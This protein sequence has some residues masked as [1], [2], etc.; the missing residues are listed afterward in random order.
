M[1]KFA[2]YKNKIIKPNEIYK[3]NI[4]V[5]SEFKCFNC[6]E[7]LLLRQSR[8]KNEN[9]VEHF[10][11]P[12]PCRNGTHIECDNINL[13][14]FIKMGEWHEMMSK[15]L[16]Y[17]FSEYFRYGNNTKHF[18]DGYD[19]NND[20]GIEF[21]NSAISIEDI[22]SREKITN[23]DWIFNVENQFIKFINTGKYCVV[24][25]PHKSWR[26]AVKYCENNVF[27]YTGFK[28][29]LWLTD[30]ES[31]Y[32]EIEGKLRHVWIIF[33]SDICIYKDVLENTCLDNIISEEG[34]KMFQDN[35]SKQNNI[36]HC[37]ICYARCKQSMYLLDEI[38]RRY[39]D[40][41]NFKKND[42]VAVKSVAGSGKTTTLL[43][44]SKINKT[45]KILYLAFNKNLIT[46][47][48]TKI[49]KQ[50]ITNL[51]PKTFDSLMRNI[52]CHH[53]DNPHKIDDLRPN[54]LH[55]K[56]TWFQNK[57]WRIK[58]QCIQY[59]T[60]FCRQTEHTSIDEYCIDKFGKSMPLLKM[61]WEKILKSYIITFDSIRKLVQI[62]H[63]A[64][65]YIDKNYDMIFIDEA[66]DFDGLMLDILLNDTTI[67]KV[68]VGDPLQAIYQWRGSIN[69]FNKLPDNTDFLEFYSTFRVGNPACDRIR[70]LF[71]KCWM[72]SKSKNTTY[73][74]KDFSDCQQ[75]VYLFR[76]WKFLLL[77]AQEQENIYIYGYDEKEKGIISLHEKL[78]KYSLSEEE[79]QEMEDDLP[80]FL[81]SY[82]SYQLHELLKN[83][84]N[85]IVTKEKATC[86]MY[87]VHS[88]KGCEH[89]NVKL[90]EDITEDEENLLYV[91]LTRGLKKISYQNI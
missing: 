27:L 30:R 56:I 84:K 55:L 72:I 6:N 31:Y 44:L 91:A 65:N 80:S 54:T 26:E 69:A 71:D 50:N 85:N 34:R 47:I 43:E 49:K 89:N 75:Y 61:I 74:D 15:S 76:S 42:I 18:V 73:F 37:K 23:L 10:Y 21:Q 19:K 35:Y 51:F 8:G 79:K 66:Q 62:N 88:F 63:W 9:Y 86:L 90:C 29:W 38:H 5:N 14:N 48:Q 1:P 60:K 33:K 58:K 12:N 25:I 39:L 78:L 45:K 64:K 7:I 82:S 11:H 16:I 83:V 13:N 46:E 57:N 81:L 32:L 77:T 22:T 52:Y 68:F 3:N 40:K 67:P 20:L 41:Y 28:E 36:E 59:I 24:E 2:L 70:A 87:T 53:K 4:S 17:N